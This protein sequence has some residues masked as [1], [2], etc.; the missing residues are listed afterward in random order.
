MAQLAK[1]SN[2]NPTILRF[3]ICKSSVHHDIVEV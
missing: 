1:K 2:K 3:V